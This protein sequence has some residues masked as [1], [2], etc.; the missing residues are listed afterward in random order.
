MEQKDI[1]TLYYYLQLIYEYLL[2]Q[3]YTSRNIVFLQVL[4]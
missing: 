4:L 1:S 3:Y 2:D